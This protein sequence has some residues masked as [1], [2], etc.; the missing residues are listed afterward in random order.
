[1]ISEF[2][3][4]QRWIKGESATDE[5]GNPTP[6]YKYEAEKFDVRSALKLFYKGE[7][8]EEAV[9][10]FKA[11]YKAIFPDKYKSCRVVYNAESGEKAVYPVYMLND[12]LDS[13]KD[14]QRIFLV[15]D[16]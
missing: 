2:L 6:Y 12:A 13:F 8:L 11:A 4:E 3:T 9:L 14:L 16:I 15:T 10:K 1:M 5:K 7:E